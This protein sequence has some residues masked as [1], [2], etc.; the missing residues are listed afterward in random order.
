MKIRLAVAV[1]LSVMLFC[2][3]VLGTKSAA[4]YDAVF[5]SAVTSLNRHELHMMGMRFFIA[6]DVRIYLQAEGGKPVS[7][8]SLAAVGRIEKARIC[9]SKSEVKM[10]VILEMRQ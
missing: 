3:S 4:G 6:P 1:F 10:I 9:V 7:L 8:K 5:T 2:S